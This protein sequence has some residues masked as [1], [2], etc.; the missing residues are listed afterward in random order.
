MG[1]ME[2]LQ[3]RLKDLREKLASMGL[4]HRSIKE[5]ATYTRISRR[6]G[7][8]PTI[9]SWQSRERKTFLDRGEIPMIQTEEIEVYMPMVRAAHHW[10][11]DNIAWDSDQKIY[12][13]ADFWATTDEI[14]KRRRDDCD[15]QAAAM[16]RQMRDLGLPDLKIGM[17][18]LVAGRRRQGH[19]IAAYFHAEDDFLV[20]DN[21]YMTREILPARELFANKVLCK[22]M[23][24]VAW[25]NLWQFGSF[26]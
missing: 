9:T 22:G 20:L 7:Y 1:I 3:A 21:G 8:E 17:V 2:H 12:G 24:P 13:R 10:V 18:M 14:L 5:P 25:F 11:L 6:S 4:V 23:R 19:M 26:A 15:G 16:W